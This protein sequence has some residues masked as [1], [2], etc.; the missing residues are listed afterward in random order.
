MLT[1][2]LLSIVLGLVCLH[3]GLAHAITLSPGDSGSPDIFTNIITGTAVA[4]DFTFSTVSSGALP[5]V[6]MREA[7]YADPNNVFGA[8]KLDFLFQIENGNID[9]GENET[10]T[11]LTATSFTGFST[12]VGYATFTS[13]C[14]GGLPSLPCAFNPDQFFTASSVSR[15]ST[16]ST[17]NFTTAIGTY[18]P[19]SD[20]FVIETNATSYSTGGSI[21]ASGATSSV[22]FAAF[23]PTGAASVPEPA[24]VALLALGFT[25]MS[26]FATR[27]RKHP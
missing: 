13:K 17:V 9:L 11:L 14:I 10:I 7:V 18:Y 15:S 4:T 23:Q 22:T 27:Q 19:A 24:S 16:G 21:T 26:L 6:T 1:S 8:G 5:N 25:G 12:D 20:I 3:G 2:R